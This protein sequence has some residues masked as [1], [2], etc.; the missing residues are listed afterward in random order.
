MEHV[1]P[2]ALAKA[3]SVEVAATT[4]QT[5]STASRIL[6]V[7]NVRWVM[8]L[9]VIS[10]HAAVTYSPFG[11]WYYR[12]HPA[13][14]MAGTLFF[15]TYQA[16]LQGFFM[17]LLFFVAGYFVPKSF[18]AKGARSFMAGRLFR[19]G[20]PTLL[21]VALLGPLTEYLVQPWALQSFVQKLSV[22]VLA[23]EFLSDTGPLWFC[24]ALLVFSAAYAVLRVAV[25]GP[26]P[27]SA[28]GRINVV[29]VVLAVQAIALTTFLTR[30]VFPVGSSILNM[31]LCYFPSYIIMFAAG[32]AASRHD[33]IR[34]VTDRFAWTIAAVCVGVAM[35]M[36]LPL[37]V[38][39]GA[40]TGQIAALS[41]GP[42]WQSAG[43][44]LWEAM[45]CVGMSFGV[46][47]GF[48]VWLTGQGRLVKF[49]SDNA[50]AVYV[51]HAP[52][53]VALGPAFAPLPLAPIAKFALLWA[54][55]AVV[56]FGV[57]APIARRLPAIGRIL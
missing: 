19:L 37:L 6:F 11:G 15:A 17:A 54:L 51:V 8:I 39:G 30:L 50:F 18:D 24:A 16:V 13:I 36:W 47:A 5:V 41:G 45:I 21:F 27:A 20:L 32:V 12:E 26:K 42:T 49:M 53:L 38:L 52:I 22:Y 28:R 23:G 25:R 56:S 55:G 33:W 43:M 1:K 31:Q 35:L 7:D 46:L 29:G 44:S 48:R 40:L 57:A 34:T 9:L 4:V 3:G 2:A 10:M 14:G